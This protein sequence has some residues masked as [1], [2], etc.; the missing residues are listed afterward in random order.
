MKK[1]IVIV[2]FLIGQFGLAQDLTTYYLIRHAEKE[3]VDPSNHDPLLTVIG[4]ERAE[5]WQ[6]IFKEVSFDMIYSTPYH[7]TRETAFPTATAKQLTVEIYDAKDLYNTSFKEKT[8][9][10]TVLVVG[11][12]NTTPALAN[13]ILG[14]EKYPQIDDRTNGNLYI[15]QVTPQGVSSKLL[16][17][18]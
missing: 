11:H 6:K 8:K 13:K 14:K 12:S 2:L 10:K 16:S 3:R 4:Q 7:R 9:G 1:S 5:N 18:E 17:I 15:L